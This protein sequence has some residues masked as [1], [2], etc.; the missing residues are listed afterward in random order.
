MRKEFFEM[1]MDLLGKLFSISIKKKEK[2]TNYHNKLLVMIKEHDL[3]DPFK[4][5]VFESQLILVTG[6]NV[7]A[8][9]ALKIEEFKNKLGGNITNRQ[10]YRIISFLKENDEGKLYVNINRFQMLFIRCYFYLIAAAML[11]GVILFLFLAPKIDG[12]YSFILYLSGLF[13]YFGSCLLFLNLIANEHLA[14]RIK[15]KDDGL[16]Q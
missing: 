13:F 9:F 1:I 8:R 16:H 11:Y 3:P 7:N 6:Q 2:E 5:I 14:V 4:D 10:L 12:L 15:K